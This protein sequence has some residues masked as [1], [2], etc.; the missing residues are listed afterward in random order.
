MFQVLVELASYI[1][2]PE[3]DIAEGRVYP[4]LS[5]S[6]PNVE[7]LIQIYSS[8]GKPKDAFVAIKYRDGWYWID[9]RDFASKRM[10]SFIMMLFSLTETGPGGTAPIVTV[11]TG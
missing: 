4:T 3:D 5:D 9:D 8:K 6:H 10:L 1:D 11:P 2:V 7:P